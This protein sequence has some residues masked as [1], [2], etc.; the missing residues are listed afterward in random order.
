MYEPAALEFYKQLNQN[1]E[2]EEKRVIASIDGHSGTIPDGLSISRHKGAMYAHI[3]EVKCPKSYYRFYR[4]MNCKT[5]DDI[6]NFDR[7]HYWQLIDEMEVSSA[8]TGEMFYYHPD[9]PKEVC[10]NAIQFNKNNLYEDFMF[11]VQRKKK[12]IEVMQSYIENINSIRS[13]RMKQ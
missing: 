4:A 11:L 6:K 10:Y 5:P 3:I 12:A 9:F 1:R 2:L 8:F 7:R 13:D